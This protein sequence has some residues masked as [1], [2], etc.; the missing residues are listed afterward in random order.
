MNISSTGKP[1][2]Q[3]DP[4]RTRRSLRRRCCRRRAVVVMVIAV[5]AVVVAVVVA[6]VFVFSETSKELP[7]GLL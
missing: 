3:R 7:S 5:A 1:I 6:V 4:Q 2:H